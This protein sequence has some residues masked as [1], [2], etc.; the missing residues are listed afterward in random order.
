MTHNS[1]TV[2]LRNAI[3]SFSFSLLFSYTF[4]SGFCSLP[5]DWV[6]LFSRHDP[7]S[8]CP[9]TYSAFGSSSSADSGAS[10]SIDEAAPETRTCSADDATT[11]C[12]DRT[13]SDRSRRN[14]DSVLYRHR[15]AYSG[16]AAAIYLAN[17]S[18]A[19]FVRKLWGALSLY[20]CDPLEAPFSNRVQDSG[21]RA[22]P[23]NCEIGV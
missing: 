4:H 3:L 7:D 18:R 11:F 1:V 20:V 5:L 19:Y 13:A 22:R 23:A 16:P 17:H 6:R 9:V 15:C 12:L 2:I 8:C 10:C 14:R 21:L